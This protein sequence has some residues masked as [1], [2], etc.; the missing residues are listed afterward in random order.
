M[1]AHTHV[2]RLDMVLE[3][4][5]HQKEGWVYMTGMQALV[6]LPIQQ[7]KRD[8]AAGLNT[9][10]YISGYRGSPVGTY[11]MSLWQA[12]KELK[13]H[14]IHFQPGVN[15]DLAATATWGS[16]LVGT[17][18]G[19][20]VDGVFSIWYGKAPGM[21]RSMDPLRHANLAG[22]NPKGGSILL[23][24]DDHG[25][26]SSTLACYSDL[27]FASLGMPLLAPSNVQDVL[28]MGLHGIAMSRYSGTLVGM[29]L[30][31]DVVEGGGSVY[32][33]PNS[34]EIVIPQGNVPDTSIKPFTPIPEQERLLWDVKLK[35]ALAYAR[36]NEL[37]KLEGPKDARIGIIAAGKAWQDLNQSLAG[38]G[39]KD[40]KLGSIPAR[41]LKI[42]MVWP[43]DPEVIA[44]F[45]DGLDT[46]ILVEEKRPLLE[47]Q[48]RTILYETEQRPRIVGKTFHG[49][50]YSAEAD[51]C[52]FPGFGEID[53]NQV[54]RVLVKVAQE[55]DADC[56]LSLPNQ[57]ETLSNLGA[58]SIRPPS[59]CAG[60]PH[61]RSTQVVDGSRALAG[62]GCHTMAMLRDPKTTNSVSHMGGEG[63]MWLGQFP[64][65]DE[66]HVFANM[67]DG[68]YFHSGLMAIRAAV[69]AGA[70]I[71]YKLLHNGFVSMTG[72]QPHD[73][74]V[75]PLQ[76][77]HQLRAE[78][79]ERIALVAD[80][81]EKYEGKNLGVGASLHPRSEMEHVQRELR[82]ISGVTVIIYDQPCATERRR[83]RKR[84]KWVD[85]DKRAFINPE[86][87]EG[88]GDCSTVSACMAIE[89]LETKL[90]R[91]RKINQS[92]CNKD[93][94]C[95]EG[96]C[97]SFVTLTGATPRKVQQTEVAID[98]SHLPL[99]TPREIDG[100][101]SILVSGIGGAGVVTVGQILA[102]AAH[103]DGYFSSN[104]DI[105][106]L[107]QKY[108][109]VHSHIKLALSPEQMRATRIAAGEADAL[110]GCDLVVAAGDEAL[111]KLT[112]GKSVAVSD[113]T[114]V[115]TSEFSKNPDW[116]LSGAEQAERLSTVLGDGARTMNAQE[117]AEKIMGDRVFANMLLM[118]ASW[119]QGGIP[120]SLEAIYH[121]IDLNGVAVVKN[122]Q[123]FELGRLAMG[124]PA[125][126]K[127]LMGDK[128]ETFLDALHEKTLDEIIAH[129][130]GE[131]IAYDGPA[132]A[133]RYT[134]KLASAKAAGLSEEALKAIARGLYK[135]LAVKDEWEVARLYCKPSF[136]ASLEEA[137][138]GEMEMTF[139]FGA[140][141]IGGVDPK[142]GKHT[143]GAV[144]G[145]TAMRFFTLMN[146]L[147]KLRGTRLDPFR[148]SEEAVLARQLLEEYEA[149][150]DFAMAQA[151]QADAEVLI[152]LLDLPEH[153]RG[154]GHVRER[155]AAEV[156]KKRAKLRDALTTNA[157]A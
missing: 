40:G 156:A 69:A 39:Y 138:E 129:R 100:S 46:I 149:D 93:F 31:T 64:F 12:E 45:A 59:F 56:G 17:F 23:V 55:I 49:T 157:I 44:K 58:G 95:I 57:P 52:A 60:C 38:L 5:L 80:E 151:N 123:A 37:N 114:V 53:P 86:V 153:I 74:E 19:A 147:R 117:L 94:S 115:P 155:H 10:G 11:D 73:G 152:E 126:A 85:P 70:P 113:T 77:V 140:W 81:P 15:E 33:S 142:T 122:K 141:P 1:T 3:D 72:G 68:T 29:K 118:G 16:Q 62:I 18:P 119:Q 25:A 20:R 148:N 97:P 78:G 127:E 79:V 4:R 112:H 2:K 54:T 137:F 106:G 103:A 143:K 116:Q 131:L 21:D 104:L 111:S 76:M 91:K 98:V 7:R 84:G 43:L 63:A 75:S 47:D 130:T 132:L 71:T 136:R 96:F 125:A 133:K 109:A 102:V 6:R 144:K 32:V 41:L 101:W 51:D 35:K 105:T 87:C 154:Y 82:D 145:K 139:Y 90:G 92:S 146:R 120:L 13:E 121:A 14:N 48:I 67:G 150:I 99:P 88:C 61:G 27:N 135:L 8:A 26:K 22:T 66:K 9:G 108:G 89:P 34:P 124:D 65:T 134:D 28:D 110:I 42:G 36:A 83:L 50:A 128:T 30:V 107:A 24:G